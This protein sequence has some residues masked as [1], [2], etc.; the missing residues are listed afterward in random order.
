MLTK[1]GPGSAIW[2]RDF[3]RIFLGFLSDFRFQVVV[4]ARNESQ[5]AVQAASC[6]AASRLCRHSAKTHTPYNASVLS[7]ILPYQGDREKKFQNEKTGDRP[8]NL[9]FSL[10]H[11]CVHFDDSLRG[12]S[13]AYDIASHVC[14]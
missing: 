6:A 7:R 10:R 3:L 4:V 13:G 9:A 8:K 5:P 14:E 12:G 1:F 2:D 11:E